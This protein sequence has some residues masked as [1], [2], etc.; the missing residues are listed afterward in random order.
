MTM[1]VMCMLEWVLKIRPVL[2]P[3]STNM[4]LTSAPVT[5]ILRG[6]GYL[7]LGRLGYGYLGL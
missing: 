6:H 4:L 7:G 1:G 2:V 5:A 3:R